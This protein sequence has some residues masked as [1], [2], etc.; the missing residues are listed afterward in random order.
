MQRGRM[1]AAHVL[2]G[3]SASAKCYSFNYAGDK[4]VAG[5]YVLYC[6]CDCKEAVYD[7]SFYE[8]V[9]FLM[10]ADV[11]F[12]LPKQLCCRVLSLM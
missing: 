8:V 9:L 7:F 12:D 4:G 10:V 1:C 2:G 6:W 5:I 3:V 11:L